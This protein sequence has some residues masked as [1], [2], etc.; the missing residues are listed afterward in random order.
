MHLDP[1]KPKIGRQ[2]SFAIG[3]RDLSESLNGIPQEGHI[4]LAFRGVQ[5]EDGG[6]HLVMT[7]RYAHEP[8]SGGRPGWTVW[9]SAVPR[10]FKGRV[11]ALLIGEA[12][13]KIARP[14]LF[15]RAGL[16]GRAGE[17][18]LDLVFDH[19][20]DKILGRPGLRNKGIEPILIRTSNC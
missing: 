14:W 12:L 20:E 17:E 16:L 18:A 10:E 3:A 4:Q 7:F 13:P 15:A 19:T 2:Q 1:Y 5:S 8:R 9:V 6:A 11:T